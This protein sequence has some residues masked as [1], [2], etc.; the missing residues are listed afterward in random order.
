MCQDSCHTNNLRRDNYEGQFSIQGK[1]IRR[2]LPPNEEMVRSVSRE[3]GA[4][5]ISLYQWLKKA[6]EGTL[7][8][9]GEVSPNRR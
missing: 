5:E 8:R 7:G 6:R 1:A 2:I 9:N 3:M 4:R